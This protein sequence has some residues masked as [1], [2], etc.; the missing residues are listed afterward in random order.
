M[1]S[2]HQLAW[3]GFATVGRPWITV[4]QLYELAK[5][6]PP[7]ELFVVH[8]P[9][10]RRSALV[11]P[12]TAIQ[13]I[14]TLKLAHDEAVANVGLFDVIGSRQIEVDYQQPAR[15]AIALAAWQKADVV[16]TVDDERRPIGLL[17]PQMLIE[18]LPERSI[19][20]HE[21]SP[22]LQ[23]AVSRLLAVGDLSGAIAAIE[24]EHNYFHS[25]SGMAQS[26]T[27]YLCAGHGAQHLLSKCPC[28]DHPSANC[29]PRKIKTP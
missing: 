2:I 11:V 12:E 29:Q 13:M 16:F 20:R 7:E 21:S 25:E 24:T 18:T 10:V 14:D 1:I 5:Y 6:S 3:R 19:I 15:L 28:H 27:P 23:Q 22:R 26:R 4:G 17:V 8:D 9:A